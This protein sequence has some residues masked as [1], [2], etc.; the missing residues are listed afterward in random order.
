MIELQILTRL[1]F[2]EFYLNSKLKLSEG[3]VE[4]MLKDSLTLHKGIRK[5]QPV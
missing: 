4:C 3:K 1:H 5:T 2:A